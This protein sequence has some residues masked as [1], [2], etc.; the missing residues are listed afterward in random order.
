MKRITKKAIYA[1]YGI[2]FNRF[3]TSEKVKHPILGWINKPLVNGNEKIGK[4]CYHFSTLPTCKTFTVVMDNGDKITIKGTCPCTC[5]KC[6]ALTGNY[7]FPSVQKALAIR[8]IIARSDLS[9]MVRCILA[10]IKADK[11]TMCRIHA[12]GDFDSFEYLTAWKTIIRQSPSVRFWTYTKIAEYET[13]FDEF[14]NANIVKSL[15]KGI[16]YNFGHCDYIMNTYE[17]LKA[18]GE[19]VHICRCGTDSEQH[20]NDCKGCSVNKYVLFIEHSTEYKAEED[21]S[22][23]ALANIINKQSSMDC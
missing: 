2:E 10:Q 7:C 6:Y 15:I 4:N 20:C 19:S 12:S 5:V 14:A 9:W 22:F 8:T 3:G 18:R 23:P 11:I 13:A 17:T 1:S 16:G 21:P